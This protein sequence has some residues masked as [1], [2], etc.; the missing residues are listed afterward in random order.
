MPGKVWVFDPS[1]GGT[2]I[3]PIVKERTEPRIRAYLYPSG[4]YDGTPEEALAL[5]GSFPLTD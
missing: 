5:A 1:R 2:K 4:K 3:T